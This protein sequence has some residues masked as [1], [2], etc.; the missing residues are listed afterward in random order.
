MS[1]WLT[2]LEVKVNPLLKFFF[3]IQLM[4]AALPYFVSDVLLVFCL[5]SFHAGVCDNIKLQCK[6]Y[7]KLWAPLS[8][9]SLS[10]PIRCC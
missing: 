4:S 6:L 8:P 9:Q 2:G 3:T 7:L 5:Y 1:D 10:W